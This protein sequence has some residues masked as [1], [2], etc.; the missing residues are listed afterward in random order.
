MV[1]HRA[2]HNTHPLLRF[3][4]ARRIFWRDGMNALQEGPIR[5]ISDNCVEAE[6]VALCDVQAILDHAEKTKQQ[7]KTNS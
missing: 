2:K 3:F 1:D 4:H 7:Q 5:F 6:D